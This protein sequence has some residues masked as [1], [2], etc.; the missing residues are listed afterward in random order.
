MSST[1]LILL[2]ALF[3]VGSA[4][5]SPGPFHDAEWSVPGDSPSKVV[6]RFSEALIAKNWA[7]CV[8]LTDPEELARNKSAF[9]PLFE[10]DS[11][12][13]LA[14]QILG[15]PR[16][17][18]LST[19]S[20]RDFNARLFAF[21]VST[22]SRGSALSRYTGVDILGEAMP[23][24][25]QSFVVYRWRLPAGERPLRGAQVSELR[26]VGNEWRLTMLADFEGLRQLL[27]QQP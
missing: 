21:F 3:S 11:S 16:Q 4:K 27:I 17:L 22:A 12:R 1:R 7:I 24:P 6:E 15:T 25:D 20:D 8:D 19:M 13:R 14:W 9:L 10:R 23:S 2:L 5:S 26:R 18:Q